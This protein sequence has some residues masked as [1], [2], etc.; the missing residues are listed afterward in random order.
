MHLRVALLAV[1]GRRW[2][3]DNDSV[4]DGTGGNANALA[5]RISIHGIGWMT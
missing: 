4:D 1:L 5:I 3:G 2:R